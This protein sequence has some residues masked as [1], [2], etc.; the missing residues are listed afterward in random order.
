VSQRR[1][2]RCARDLRRRQEARRDRAARAAP[3][4]V[5]RARGECRDGSRAVRRH[6]SVRLRGL[7]VTDLRTLCGVGEL[8]RFRA[9]L[10]PH[11][12]ARLKSSRGS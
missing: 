10:T 7:E 11:L 12:L 3:L 4:L 1:P 9:D 2:P 8:S 6:Q 5:P